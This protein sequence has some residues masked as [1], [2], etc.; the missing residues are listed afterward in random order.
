M[1][2]MGRGVVVT[3]AAISSAAIDEV[4]I[5][6]QRIREGIFFIARNNIV[7][8]TWDYF[9]GEVIPGFSYS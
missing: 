4:L 9:E 6:P 2:V 3:P 5:R 1:E 7:N 8:K